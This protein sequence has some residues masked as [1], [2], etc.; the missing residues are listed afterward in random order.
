MCEEGVAPFEQPLAETGRGSG[1]FSLCNHVFSPARRCLDTDRRQAEVGEVVRRGPHIQ[2][3]R[4]HGMFEAVH[5]EPAVDGGHQFGGEPVQVHPR[6]QTPRLFELG[7]RRPSGCELV[8]RHRL[9]HE[10]P[11]R[12]VVR[13]PQLHGVDHL[14]GAGRPQS[15][16]SRVP[17]HI[18]S[19]VDHRPLVQPETPERRGAGGGGAQQVAN[20]RDEVSSR[21]QKGAD[22]DGDC[23]AHSG[24]SWRRPVEPPRRMRT[25]LGGY[26]RH[27]GSG[28]PAPQMPGADPVV[29]EQEVLDRVLHAPTAPLPVRHEVPV[30]PRFVLGLRRTPLR[31]CKVCEAAAHQRLRGGGDGPGNTHDNQGRP[32]A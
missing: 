21:R 11:E 7:L 20:V 12:V 19:P 17:P 27:P 13:A 28:M 3:P 24:R 26:Q 8:V 1:E 23:A 25:R 16:G 10:E 5:D 6:V 9:G 2:V 14:V 31:A 18:R 32:S 22:V 30:G 29:L 15:Q 4:P